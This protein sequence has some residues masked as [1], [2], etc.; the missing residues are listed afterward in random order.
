M[1]VFMIGLVRRPDRRNRMLACL[2]E[3]AF[4]YT[5]FDAVDGRWVNLS[6]VPV[7]IT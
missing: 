4:N 2:N 1:Q 5:I 7:T 3:L 6:F